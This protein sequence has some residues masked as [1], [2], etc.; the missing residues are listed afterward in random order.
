MS[1]VTTI[2]GRMQAG[3]AA[4]S[5]ELLPLVYDELRRIAAARMRHE[6]PGNTLQATGLVHEVWI[7]LVA[8][9]FAGLGDNRDR[10]F[11][12]AAESMRRILVEA[13]RRKATSRHGGAYT[14]VQFVGRDPACL[15][16][17]AEVVAVNDALEELERDD[18]IAA[19]LVKLHY[20]AGLSLEEAGELLDLS[21]ATAY[22][23]W[24]YARTFLRAALNE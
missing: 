16:P 9:P 13:A 17:A 3:D 2:L 21:R 12:A 15:C 8:M 6:K 11:A 4:A 5:D 23:I 1:D 20:F 18:A 19:Q 14:R 10:F 22:R 7:R 24:T